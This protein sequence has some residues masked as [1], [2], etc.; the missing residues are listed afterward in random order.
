MKFETIYTDFK[1]L[2][3]EKSD[4]FLKSEKESLIYN[5][6]DE[7]SYVSFGLVIMPFVFELLKNNDK[8]R[9][10]KAFSF[11]EE[12]ANS[13][14]DNIQGLLQFTVLEN[15]TTESKKIYKAAQKYIGPKTKEFVNQVATYMAIDRME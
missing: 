10:E 3:P 1:N 5:D 8:C 14:D 11:F 15:L 4:E 13:Q 2:F 6:G 9:L 12:M 7:L